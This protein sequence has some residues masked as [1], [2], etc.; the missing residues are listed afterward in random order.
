MSYCVNCGVELDSTAK[1]CPLCHTEVVNPRTAADTELP[2]PFP[3]RRE[4]VR[5]VDRKELILLLTAM[6]ASVALCSGVLNLFFLHSQRPWSLYVVGAAVMLWIWLVPPLFVRTMPLWLRLFLDA[7][8]VGVYVYLI[9]IDLRGKAWF[10]GLALPIILLLGAIMMALGIFLGGKSRSILTKVTV[11]IGAVGIF[12]C[13]VEFFVD[14]WIF[15][16]WSA[17]WSIVVLT[18]CVA[19][20]IP[21]IVVR[22]RPVLREEVRRRFHF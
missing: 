10:F 13:G 17:G 11:V 6:L 18:V 15:G 4:E 2:P 8:A 19:L 14:R 12:L 5:P 21:L 3:T 22:R 7:A 16:G 9:S 20:I 1:A